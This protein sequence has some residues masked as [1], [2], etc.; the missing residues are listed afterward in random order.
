MQEDAFALLCYFFPD[1]VPLALIDYGEMNLLLVNK[2]QLKIDT[3]LRN[4]TVTLQ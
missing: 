1:I 2:R 3:A 4:S